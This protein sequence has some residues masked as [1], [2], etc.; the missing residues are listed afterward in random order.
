M[1]GKY[2]GQ[3]CSVLDFYTKQQLTVGDVEKSR[4][5]SRN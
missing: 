1:G 2:S 5:D 3:G 4:L